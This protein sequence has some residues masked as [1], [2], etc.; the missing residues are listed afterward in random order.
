MTTGTHKVGHVRGPTTSKVACQDVRRGSIGLGA[1]PQQLKFLPLPPSG[2]VLP[3][4]E[5]SGQQ[6]S[7]VARPANSTMHD[8]SDAIC[9]PN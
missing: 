8:T 4:K 1:S 2:H 9:S 3:P 6:Q 7:V 5:A